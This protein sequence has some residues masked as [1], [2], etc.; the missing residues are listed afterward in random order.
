M[1][2]RAKMSHKKSVC[3]SVSLRSKVSLCA[4]MTLRAKMLA[5]QKWHRAYVSLRAKESLF[6]KF[7]LCLSVT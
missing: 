1:L 7:P 4:E 3:A 2:I 5:V 6:A